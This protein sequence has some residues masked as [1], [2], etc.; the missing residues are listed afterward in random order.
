M[1]RPEVYYYNF[2]V[3][4]TTHHSLTSKF[5]VIPNFLEFGEHLLIKWNKSSLILKNNPTY[6]L[7]SDFFG[8]HFMDAQG[9]LFVP[10]A[11]VGN[12]G[13]ALLTITTSL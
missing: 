2:C 11:V 12:Q 4:Y 6:S 5:H 8:E 3:R 10:G 7:E 13:K 1:Q 9:A